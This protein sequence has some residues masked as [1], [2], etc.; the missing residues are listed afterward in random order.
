A[1]AGAGPADDG[2]V[3][4]HGR[5]A[6][7]LRADAVADE[8]GGQ[9]QPPRRCGLVGLPPAVLLEPA[10]V[11]GQLTGQRAGGKRFHVMPR[12]PCSKAIA[13]SRDPGGS[14]EAYLPLR[15]AAKRKVDRLFAAPTR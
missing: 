10:E 13:F 2:D 7:E 9:P 15:V 8:G 14:A 3:Q 12:V 11:V 5:L 6:V 4:R 1:L